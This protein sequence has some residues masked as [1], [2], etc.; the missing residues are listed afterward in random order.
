MSFHNYAGFSIKFNFCR[1]ISLTPLGHTLL[2]QMNNTNTFMLKYF[3][4]MCIFSSY[5]SHEKNFINRVNTYS[6]LRFVF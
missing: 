5:V 6:L 4:N 3:V 2:T 1:V